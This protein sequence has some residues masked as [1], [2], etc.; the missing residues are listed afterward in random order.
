[1]RPVRP[2]LDSP[3]PTWAAPV[4]SAWCQ[5]PRSSRFAPKRRNPARPGDACS[6]IDPAAPA[7]VPAGPVTRD[8]IQAQDLSFYPG[9]RERFLRPGRTAEGQGASCESTLPR[10][11]GRRSPTGP[12]PFR[13]QAALWAAPRSG[14]WSSGT[15]RPWP[16]LGGG[17][18]GPDHHAW[19]FTGPP[20][21]Q[22]PP[23]RGVRRR[24]QLPS[25]GRRHLRH[26]PAHPPWR[27]PRR[28]PDRP[29]GDSLRPG[30]R[31]VPRGG[32]A[33]PRA[34]PGRVHPRR[35]RPP[36]RSR[37]QRPPQGPRGTPQRRGASSW[38]SPQRP[39]PC[40]DTVPSRAPCPPFV[41]LSLGELTAAL[42]A[43]LLDPAQTPPRG[44]AASHGRLARDR[45]P[46]R[47]SPR[48]RRSYVLDLTDRLAG[49]QP[50]DALAA[51]ATVVAIADEV[52][53]AADS[54]RNASSPSWTRPSAPAAAPVPSANASRPATAASSAGFAS[55]PS[56]TPSLTSSVPTGTS[57]SSAAKERGRW[58]QRRGRP[59]CMA[60]KAGS[61]GRLAAKT[62]PA[63]SATARRPPGRSKRPTAASLSAPPPPH[64]LEAAF[65]SPRPPSAARPFPSTA[66][67]SAAEPTRPPWPTSTP[68]RYTPPSHRPVR[69]ARPARVA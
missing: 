55:T 60:D 44:A 37:R 49:G 32:L 24:P 64:P 25:R 61:F 17:G 9:V 51:A 8:W 15:M 63:S 16:C 69:R 2:L 21:R 52:A 47:R 10:P 18:R 14:T 29:E 34:P 43:A 26:L 23:G 68:L 33:A 45:P 35:G 65:L 30:R 53:A 67:P 3:W 66:S 1:M 59:W 7:P 19:L 50:S 4:V 12:R 42:G 62:G 5:S 20:D 46:H 22:A 56:A 36:H 40:V 58:V 6:T 27:S 48:T 41:S 28:P 11:G 13:P 57:P 54:A 38:S 31:A 39:R